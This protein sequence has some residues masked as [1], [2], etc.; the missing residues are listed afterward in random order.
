[1]YQKQPKSI[2]PFAIFIFSHDDIWGQGGGGAPHPHPTVVGRSDTSRGRGGRR[3][4]EDP[5][6]TGPIMD[7]FEL[8][9]ESFSRYDVRP[10][11]L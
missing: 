7:S 5:H 8:H 6:K 10:G 11:H 2:L 3:R 4:T 9:R 1:M